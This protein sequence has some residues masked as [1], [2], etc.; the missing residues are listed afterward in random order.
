MPAWVD[1][2]DDLVAAWS[3]F[4]PATPDPSTVMGELQ[5]AITLTV[6]ARKELAGTLHAGSAAPTAEPDAYVK[7]GTATAALALAAQ[8]VVGDHPPRVVY[9]NGLGD[10]DTH[11]GEAE[12][13]PA[14]LAD[15]DAG[16][17]SFFTTLDGRGRGRPGPGDDG[18][19]VR[20]PPG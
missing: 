6:H 7:D 12:R 10:Y 16:I 13:H 17:E 2:P 8:L 3:R 9:V 4:A 11:Q 20:P 19:R 14:L 18:L 15:L 1:T 5:R